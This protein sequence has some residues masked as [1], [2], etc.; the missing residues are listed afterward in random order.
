MTTQYLLLK[1]ATVLLLILSFL[2]AP[3]LPALIQEASADRDPPPASGF[4][5]DFGEG[6]GPVME[7]Y[8]VVGPEDGYDER[9]GY[10]LTTEAEPFLTHSRGLVEY[11]PYVLQRSWVFNQYVSDLT[12]DGL[13]STRSGELGFKLDLPNG[14]YRVKLWLG[15][16]E[17]GV[18]S[19]NASYNGDWLLEE[20]SAFHT[21]HRGLYFTPQGSRDFQDYGNAF[22]YTRDVEISNGSLELLVSG[23]DTNYQELLAEELDKEPP[24]SY[25]S[26]MSTGTLKPSGGTGPWRFIGGPFTNASVLGLEVYPVPSLPF[27]GQ[28]PEVDMLLN[29]DALELA[30]AAHAMNNG[31]WEVAYL[32]WENLTKEDLTGDLLVGRAQLGM[33]LAGT[34][35]QDYELDVLEQMEQDL[36]DAGRENPRNQGVKDLL[37]EV[38]AFNWALDV[39][40]NRGVPVPDARQHKNHFYEAGKAISQLWKIE[41]SSL[42]YPKASLWR[43]RAL[44]SLDPH[45]WTSASGTGRDVM[46]SLRSLDPDNHYI[47]FYQNTSRRD[48]AVWEQG[49]DII[50]TIGEKDDWYLRNHTQGF[51]DAPE[52]AK[53]LR[54]EL[55]WLYAITDWWVDHKQQEDGSIGGGWTDDVEMIGLFGFDALISEGAD[56]KSLEGGRKFVDGM[57]ASGQLDMEK[58]FSTAFAD[59][60]HSAELT[61]DSLPMM[62][63]TDFGNPYWL[64]FSMKTAKL[65]RDL[66]MGENDKGNLQFRANHLSA[67]KVGTGGQAEDSWINFRATLPA[68]WVWWYSRDPEVEELFVRWAES[69]LDAAMSTDKGKPEGVI[70]AMIAWPTGEIGGLDAPNWYEGKQDGSVNYKWE[71]QQYKSYISTLLTT[72]Y[73]ATGN[74]SFLEP[75]RLESELAEKYLRGPGGGR[76]PDVGSEE[77]AALILGQKAIN[78]YQA[79]LDAYG[80]PGGT[81][82]PEIWT[83]EEVVTTCENGHDY[84]EK[85]YP[86]M[87]TEASATDRVAFVGIINPFLIYTGGSTGGALLAPKFTYSGVDLG[88]DFAAMVR[89]ADR[90]GA[91]ISLYKFDEDAVLYYEAN[92]YP[93]PFRNYGS[94]VLWDLEPGATYRF[95]LGPDNNS[96]GVMDEIEEESSFVFTS[97]GMKIPF[98]LR[99]M[100]E[101]VLHIQKTENGSGFTLLP[102]LVWGDEEPIIDKKNGTI[103]MTLY[104]LGPVEAKGVEVILEWVPLVSSVFSGGYYYESPWVGARTKVD[105]PAAQGLEFSS[106]KVTLKVKIFSTNR[107]DTWG[108]YE[109]IFDPEG[110]IQQITTS[111]DGVVWTMQDLNGMPYEEEAETSDVTMSLGFVAIFIIILLLSFPKWYPDDEESIASP[112]PKTRHPT[113]PALAPFGHTGC[114][115]LHR[116]Q[117]SSLVSDSAA[118]FSLRKHQPPLAEKEAPAKEPPVP[119]AEF[120]PPPSEEPEPPS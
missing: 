74:T 23:N 69:W 50:S 83:P 12:V 102:D 6:R 63:A 91:V 10:G 55:N 80:L 58:G 87:T 30:S 27:V 47:N 16:L 103:T 114:E 51:E 48:P 97:K 15:D 34:L 94:L 19:M 38:R 120:K 3:L 14:S 43:A 90:N 33:Y 119:T 113:P 67:T 85:C 118:V 110:K 116:S 29:T 9:T 96:D 53:V 98:T 107:W 22:P 109:L 106:V 39:Y 86:L 42:L 52:W 20:A 56:E 41:P 4:F 40:F 65:M 35:H 54:E 36:L 88:R 57:L 115:R 84:I 68:W 82:A 5:F 66:W 104:N 108:G 61:G 92:G 1:K 59:T 37:A 13:R 100:E 8:T 81:S 105:V 99:S 44:Y 75:L 25:L 31:D 11:S 60:E 93:C 64:E 45:R 77:W 112:G 32:S 89:Q 101:Y 73:E 76:E 111:N 7:G 46:E 117:P 28:P 70:P 62:I 95:S 24:N 49:T 71:R 79:I 2:L 18:Y 26:W 21:V 72:A 17:K 78:R